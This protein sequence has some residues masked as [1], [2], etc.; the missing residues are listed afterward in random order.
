MGSLELSA[1]S[2][3]EPGCVNEMPL[4]E[5][6][7]PMEEAVR[8]VLPHHGNIGATQDRIPANAELQA[9]DAAITNPQPPNTVTASSMVSGS[10]TANT[11]EGSTAVADIP[12]ATTAAAG[13][14]EASGAHIHIPETRAAIVNELL[15]STEPV[16]TELIVRTVKANAESV[17]S[18]KW[19]RQK[20]CDAWLQDG[21]FKQWLAKVP[22][23]PYHARCKVCDVV[24]KTGKSEL[25]KHAKAKYHL[26]AMKAMDETRTVLGITAA[27]DVEM[28][29]ERSMDKS[30]DSSFQ[31]DED[32]SPPQPI[33]TSTPAR[34]PRC[35]PPPAAFATPNVAPRVQ[36][37][38]PDF[39]GIAVWGDQLQE[40]RLSDYHGKFLVLFFYPQDFGLA[41]CTE[42]L[43]HSDRAA[44]LRSANAELLAVSPDSYCTHLAWTNTPRKCGG[45]GRINFPL[46]S[47][48]SKKIARDY[49]VHLED[50]GVALRASF[51]IDP[52]SMVRHV[53]VN[54]LGLYR[55]ADETLRLLKVLEHFERQPLAIRAS[56]QPESANEAAAAA[57][58]QQVAAAGHMT[59]RKRASK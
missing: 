46:L 56:W 2:L 8:S 6:P 7:H 36:S 45:L 54:D 3:G 39:N 53:S 18:T 13:P 41:C 37:Y 22:T 43:E 33:R 59:L 29:L 11:A 9:F 24:L 30:V 34:Q 35:T 42:L 48:F 21:R 1:F 40:T 57:E 17:Q 10:T 51:I 12:V 31:I 25:E 44:D 26:K 19:R 28:S 15:T 20:F 23:T 50:T 4:A 14:L 32:D 52:R 38:A 27:A 49:N 47:D 55:S 16:T 5:A 58:E